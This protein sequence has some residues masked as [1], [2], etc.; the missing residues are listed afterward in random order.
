MKKY[1]ISES[2][3]KEFWG[4][5]GKKQKPNKLQTVIDNDPVLRKLDDELQ[6]MIDSYYP[7]LKKMQKEKPA[8]FKWLQD[9]GF[10]PK[11]FK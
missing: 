2:N 5:F 3:L 10:V 11:D 6:D 7:K 4:W 1:K 8:D 9:N